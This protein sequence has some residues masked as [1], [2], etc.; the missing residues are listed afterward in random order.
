ML[1]IELGC[2]S[3]GGVGVKRRLD[4]VPQAGNVHGCECAAASAEGWEMA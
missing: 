4:P 1:E 2:L 3:D